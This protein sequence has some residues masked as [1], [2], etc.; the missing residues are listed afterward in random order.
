MQTR[1]RDNLEVE[2]GLE[3]FMVWNISW[4]GTFHGL[5]RFSKMYQ[6]MK[7]SKP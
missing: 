4:F 2:H 5:E 7:C 3:H 1:G 6:I